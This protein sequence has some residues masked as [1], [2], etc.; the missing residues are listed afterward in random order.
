[1]TPA[2][3]LDRALRKKRLKANLAW[4]SVVVVLSIL[5]AFVYY[6]VAEEQ[7][8]VYGVTESFGA[9]QSKF[10]PRQFWVARLESGVLVR[11]YNIE[12]YRFV[13]GQKLE[14]FEIKSENGLVNYR[15]AKVLSEVHNKS[16]Q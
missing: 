11:I 6:D 2:D 5:F 13:K 1:M 3:K 12:N 4:L 10:V 14:I 9:R 16:Q 15:L 8:T 7:N